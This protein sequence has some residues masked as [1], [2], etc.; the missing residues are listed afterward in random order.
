[1]PLLLRRTSIRIN[2][3]KSHQLMF[4][5]FESRTGQ[6]SIYGLALYV[7]VHLR[8]PPSSGRPWVGEMVSTIHQ[9]EHKWARNRNASFPQQQTTL[10]EFAHKRKDSLV[11]VRCAND[12]N[13]GFGGCG[14]CITCT[15]SACTPSPEWPYAS[16]R[17]RP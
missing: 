15:L 7:F 4:R 12:G 10:P 11:Y 13:I 9:N 6:L 16:K 8:T 14:V 3:Y 2:P 5:F 17:S 1:M